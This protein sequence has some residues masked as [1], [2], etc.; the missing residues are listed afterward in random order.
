MM[1][2]P[3]IDGPYW[4]MKPGFGSG[5]LHLGQF[6][7]EVLERLGKPESVTRKYKGQYFYNYPSLGLEVDFGI[8]GGSIACLYFFRE[9]FRGNRQS[10]M[11]TVYGIR[12][13]DSRE[14]V[15]ESLGQP[16]SE[17]K[18]VTLNM[19]GTLEAW[20]RYDIGINFQ[21]ASDDAI[22]M[23]TLTSPRT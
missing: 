9:G 14:R 1:K 22:N 11:E 2:S 18:A 8:R 7:R 5:W 19:G 17:G 10:P 3:Q 20:F 16:T 13:G 21:F 4:R 23:I 15:L 6:E 12:P